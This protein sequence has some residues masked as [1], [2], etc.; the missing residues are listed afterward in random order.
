MFGHVMG[1]ALVWVVGDEYHP[2]RLFIELA[3][4]QAQSF[5][6]FNFSFIK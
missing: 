5:M 3:N 4:A 6:F 1:W 2:K